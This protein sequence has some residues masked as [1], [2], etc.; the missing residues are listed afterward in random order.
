MSFQARTALL[1]LAPLGAAA[2]TY[3]QGLSAEEVRAVVLRAAG[4]AQR[5]GGRA[6]IA[7]VDAEG[8]PLAVFRM[9]GAP[10]ASVVEGQ[11]PRSAAAGACGREGLEGLAAPAEQ[12]ALGK[13]A[14]AALLSTA[15]AAFSTRTA[16]FLAQDHFPPGI[17]FTPGGPGLGVPLSS[18]SCSDLPAPRTALGLAGDPGGVPLYR[19]GTLIGGLGVEGDGLYGVDADPLADAA[20]WEESAALAGATAFAAPE[21]LRA[22]SVLIDGIRLPFASTAPLDAGLTAID[23][24]DLLPPQA[25]GPSRLA[26]AS[27]NGISGTTLPGLALRGGSVLSAADVER[28]AGQAL[29]QAA[30]TRSTVRHPLNSPAHVTVAV[31]DVDGSVLTLFRAIDAPLSGFDAAAQSARTAAFFSGP[32]A[33]SELQRA[34]LAAFVREVPLDG[35]VAYTSRA[36]GFLSQPFLP[37]GIAAS[38]PGPFSVPAPPVWSPF[39]TGLQTELL[40][41]ALSFTVAGTAVPACARA[42]GLGNG[43]ALAPGGV[44]LYKDG[45]LAG[46]VGVSGDGADQDDLIAAAASAGFEASP[47]RRSDRLIVRGVRVPYLKFPRHPEL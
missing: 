1:A 5:L 20:S 3:A 18:L 23:G 47:E 26:G 21:A 34:G 27:V 40:C 30:K 42:A 41:E 38:E 31:V 19:D 29:A 22:D 12:V 8:G 32:A 7:V 33:G 10:L 36:I 17:D 39:D 24:T 11:P 43:V 13:A 46:A 37:P 35:T 4:E 16:G 44:P 14:T 25:A 45:R 9:S 15:A 2:P 28:I 6:T